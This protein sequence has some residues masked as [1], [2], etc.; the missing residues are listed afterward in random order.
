MD[1]IEREAFRQQKNREQEHQDALVKERMDKLA[2]TDAMQYV[3]PEDYDYQSAAL[4]TDFSPSKEGGINLPIKYATNNPPMAGYDIATGNKLWDEPDVNGFGQA[5]FEK[6]RNGY[7][8]TQSGPSPEV[9]DGYFLLAANAR[10]NGVPV[11]DLELPIDGEKK[12]LITSA[13]S[14][15]DYNDQ[16]E[17][18]LVEANKKPLPPLAQEPPREKDIT[19]ED[20]ENSPEF[21]ADAQKLYGYFKP[22]TDVPDNVGLTQFTVQ[23]VAATLSNEAR[24]AAVLL[25]LHTGDLDVETAKAFYR[26]LDDYDRLPMMAKDVLLGT[27]EGVITS[28]MTYLTAGVGKALHAAVTKT[29]GKMIFKEQLRKY[30]SKNM[31][32]TAITG[33]GAAVDAAIWSGGEEVMRQSVAVQ[34]GYQGGIDWNQ[35]GTRAAWGGTAGAIL[36]GGL[37]FLLTDPA[38]RV[39]GRMINDS[40]DALSGPDTPTAALGKQRGSAGIEPNTMEPDEDHFLNVVRG[41]IRP[42]SEESYE[43]YYNRQSEPVDPNRFFSRLN[44]AIMGDGKTPGRWEMAFD[45][46]STKLQ[47]PMKIME[48]MNPSK[49]YKGLPQIS[50]YELDSM[51]IQPWL[52]GYA[53]R[54]EKVSRDMME[55]FMYARGPRL[56]TGFTYGWSEDMPSGYPELQEIVQTRPSP[57]SPDD[58]SKS[59]G[60]ETDILNSQISQKI[61]RNVEWDETVTDGVTEYRY[62]DPVTNEYKYVPAGDEPPE[63]TVQR[64]VWEDI[65]SELRQMDRETL[66]QLADD[67]D[68]DVLTTQNFDSMHIGNL[69]NIDELDDYHEMRVFIPTNT[70]DQNTVA[71]DFINKGKTYDE[72]G[73]YDQKRVDRV[74]GLTL[75][76]SNKDTVHYYGDTNRMAAVRM[77]TTYDINNNKILFI[78]ELQSDSAQMHMRMAPE[79]ERALTHQDRADAMISVVDKMSEINPRG[80]DEYASMIDMVNKG[81]MTVGELDNQVKR[82]IDA[83]KSKATVA[84]NNKQDDLAKQFAQQAYELRDAHDAA[85]QVLLDKSK[86]QSYQPMMGGWREAM[87]T[88]IIDHAIRQGYDGIAFPNT[89]R[90]VGAIQGWTGNQQ[91]GEGVVKMYSDILPNMMNKKSFKKI[92]GT[93]G[94]EQGELYNFDGIKLDDQDMFNM[95]YLGGEANKKGKLAKP[96]YSIGVMST[97]AGVVQMPQ[98]EDDGENL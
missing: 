6:V 36:G 96:I 95:M 70:R 98:G 97:A 11:E 5:G 87:M 60:L 42:R 56:E 3:K 14:R 43:K 46:K 72:L 39:T 15:L 91:G 62:R 12:N 24:M 18:K 1:D 34:G 82:S 80:A 52:E 64:Q 53:A 23:T 75:D 4:E 21:V 61:M 48:I 45:K 17:Q 44:M 22:D 88:Q 55:E 89:T 20:L 49:Q 68:V 31:A 84:K 30:I 76:G 69:N 33:G 93:R 54:G 47:D 25:D 77:N 92:H 28:A 78:N 57:Q 86:I 94:V 38:Q 7:I 81:E 40:L 58:P 59:L 9:L 26:V 19:Q 37:G 90:Q 13:I 85:A 51:G 27:F 65:H 35:V 66:Y 8:N 73:E 32:T 10:E 67:M 74:I 41:D 83:L 63:T 16:V 71:A 29:A 50:K 79:A 2:S